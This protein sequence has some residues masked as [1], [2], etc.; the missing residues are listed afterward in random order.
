MPGN[1]ELELTGW[2]A[3]RRL[4]KKGK[5]KPTAVFYQRK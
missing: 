4:G 2:E 1:L 3:I 5:D